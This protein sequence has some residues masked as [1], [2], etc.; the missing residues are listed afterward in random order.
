VASESPKTELS[1]PLSALRAI[2]LSHHLLPNEE[3]YTLEVRNRYVE[4]LQPHYAGLRPEGA[5][6]I[7]SEVF[8]W[9]HV[10]TH[11]EAPF[12]YFKDGTDVAGLELRRVVGECVLIDFTDKA[13]GE[14]IGRA[15]LEERAGGVS[16]GDIVFVR[17]DSG[18]YRTPQ[19][20]DRP[21]FAEDAIGL[22]VE[23]NISCLG[24]DCSG[25]ERRDLPRQPNHTR[26][27]RNEIPL[28]EHLA[29]LDRLRTTRFFVVAV[30]WRVRGLE[31]SPVSVIAFES[32]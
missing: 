18:N 22:L 30:P 24:V 32:E 2:E 19:S 7:M 1:P 28:I 20:H 6:Y 11:I 4:E 17:T 9:S 16:A 23:R 5:D 15:E 25:I 31:A 13:V 21:Y 8:L 14:E 3:E 29:H 12:H 26:L 27:F 10:G